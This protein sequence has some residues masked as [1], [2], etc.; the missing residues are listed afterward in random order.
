MAFLW[1][2]DGIIYQ[3]Y[4]RSFS[5]SNGD[6]IGDIPGILSR[7]DYLADLGVDAI[8]LS[9]IFP[10]PDVDFGYDVSD[11]TAIDPKYG[12]MEDFDCLVQQAHHRGIRVVLDLVLN[13]T[14]SLHPWF[15]E[16]RKSK[17]NPYRDWYLWKA[18]KK[19]GQ[20]PNNW[21][22]IFGGSGWQ[23]DPATQEYYF[24]MFDKE[25]PDLNWR[26]PAVRRALLDVFRFWLDKGVDGFRLDVFN[27]YFKHKDLLDNP[28]VL[29]LRS[30]DRQQH[31]HDMDQP[32]MIPLLQEIRAL[33][34]LY[35]ERY[36][37]GE[38]LLGSAKKA[39]S[40]TGTDRLHA[41]FN[42]E[43]LEN[44]WKP[45]HF[46]GAV[47]RWEQALGSEDWP[48][49]V[50]NNHDVIRTA[51]RW[52]CK[53]DDAR[54][55]VAATLLLTLRGTPFLYYGEEIGMRDIPI[56]SKDQV[57]DPVGKMYWPF[58][59]GR[60]GCRA[61]MQWNADEN[62]GFSAAGG[63]LWLPVN[64]DYPNRNVEAQRA[65]STSLLNFYRRLITLRRQMPA[66]T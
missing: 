29:G 35:P 56:R 17:D 9:P 2:R 66:L 5:D 38:T 42:F 27:M 59:K 28:P 36:M 48:N 51:T 21:Q 40:Y 50:L 55:K 1:W 3:V 25:Q 6:G 62:A 43:F 64:A 8:W 63:S 60:D 45:N 33:L 65:D 39:A 7:L 49:Y 4:P 30:F 52:R 57:L 12:S 54:L 58:Y 46:L 37:V 19:N 11:Y 13:H 31:I 15:I 14:S 26:N 10:S 32:D 22:S 34:D 18:G 53:P 47:Q 20:P 41:A 44:P 23:Y 16:S 61:P 24:H